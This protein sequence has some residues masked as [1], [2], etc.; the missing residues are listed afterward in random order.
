LLLE[1]NVRGRV[2]LEYHGRENGV[3]QGHS[4]LGG[5]EVEREKGRT[6]VPA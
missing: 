2:L 4:P 3:E 5:Q 1:S 6:G